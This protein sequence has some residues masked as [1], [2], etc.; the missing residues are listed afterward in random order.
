V[1]NNRAMAP[2][3]QAGAMTGPAG[4]K[5]KGG[6]NRV[7]PDSRGGDLFIVDN[8]DE[9]W[10]GVRYLRELTELATG[11]D[12][13]TGYFE[14]CSLLDLDGD[15]Q[16]LD[17]IR[18]LMGDEITRRTKK[19]LLDAVRARAEES[20]DRSLDADKEANPFLDGVPAIVEALKT[21]KI[22]CRVYNKDKFHA[23]TYI[24]HAKFEVVG[25]KALVGSSN[26][27]RPGLT[28][29]V[30]L[31][32]Q[33]QSGREVAQLREWFEQYWREAID[34]TYDVLRL[35]SRHTH[36]YSPFDVYAKALQE[37][38]RGHEIT[39]SEWDESRSEMF[40]KLDQYQKEAYGLEFH[41]RLPFAPGT[42]TGIDCG[43]S[44]DGFG[45]YR[46][47][48]KRLGIYLLCALFQYLQA[49]ICRL[50]PQGIRS[51]PRADESHLVRGD[52][53]TWGPAHRVAPHGIAEA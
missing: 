28:Q 31:N 41:C 47:R 19:A 7:T 32:I 10:K 21:C 22:E 5:F 27:T 44:P 35:I 48:A 13:A 43:W 14:I 38:F 16:K 1:A 15:W 30:E 9:G 50:S 25:S 45:G 33:V 29:N 23:K 8:S 17:K 18:I 34:V 40:P 39:A 52:G 24:T 46:R 53:C 37:F 6:K 3:R 2:P 26:F 4:A 11:F 20:L 12:I 36:E 42:A 49:K 51:H